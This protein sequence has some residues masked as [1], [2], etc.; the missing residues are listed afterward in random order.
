M[1]KPWF[2]GTPDA[3][4]RWGDG[5]IDDDIHFWRQWKAAGNT[6]FCAPRRVIGHCELFVM[7]PN[8]NL[9]HIMQHASDYWREGA[10]RGVWR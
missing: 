2:L 7:W 5:R 10:P 6:V 9:E 8:I 1:A 3:E 4:G